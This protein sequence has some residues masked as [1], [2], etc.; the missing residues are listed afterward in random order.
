MTGPRMLWWPRVLVLVYLLSVDV[1]VPQ[2]Y[3]PA[4]LQP[5]LRGQV[6]QPQQRECEAA[7]GQY[8]NSNPT[9]S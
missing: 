8:T 9:V 2:S 6:D 7:R 3:H 5:H 4:A 1:E